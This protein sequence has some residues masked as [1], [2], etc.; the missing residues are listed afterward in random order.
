MVTATLASGAYGLTNNG[1]LFLGYPVVGFTNRIQSSGTCLDS[2]ND[3]F[4][5]AC[6]W[7]YRIKGE[8][9]HQTAFSVPLS[10]VKNF[11][12]DVQKL[13]ELEP[14]ALCG[15]ELYNGIILRY[16]TAS[17]AYLGKTED[18]VD[19]DIT[20]YRSK[21]PLNPRL[22]EDIL[23]E[24]EQIGLFKYGASPHWGKNRNLAFV[25]AINKYPN[26]H[27]FLKVKKKYDPK[28]VFSS[29]WTDQVLG[30]KKGITILKDGCALEGLCICSQDSHCAPNKGYYCRPGRVYKEARVCR[31]VNQKSK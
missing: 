20:Y 21:D 28:G 2:L 16:V 12:E 25:G 4:I 23:E 5:T 10:V 27:K 8:V 26:A 30:L 22:F 15:L 24:I 7:D 3:G 18:A 11:I 9:Y 1:V 29:E 14:E 17:S 13:L 19:F 6:A 31:L